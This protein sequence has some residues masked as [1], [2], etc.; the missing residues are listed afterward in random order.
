[1]IALLEENIAVFKSQSL[2]EVKLLCYQKQG[3]L[4]GKL[5]YAVL[6]QTKCI[7]SSVW[8]CS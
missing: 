1:M 5:K 7:L 3:L 8:S 2:S 4:V 6:S